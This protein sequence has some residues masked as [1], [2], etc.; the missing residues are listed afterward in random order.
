[1]SNVVPFGQQQV[2]A[3]A[4]VRSG[5]FGLKSPEQALALMALCEAEGLHPAKA[6]QRYHI[7]QGKAA[8]KA[9]TMLAEFQKA[10]G[11]VKWT[12]YT[13]KQVT[14]V[15]WHKAG[16]EVTISWDMI[17]AAKAGLSSKDVWRFYPRAMMRSRCISEGVRTVFPGVVEGIYTPEELESLPPD[18]GA[19]E[20]ESVRVADTSAATVRKVTKEPEMPQPSDELK[21]AAIELSKMGRA[22]FDDWFKSRTEDERKS[23]VRGL[24]GLH[25]NCELADERMAAAAAAEKAAADAANAPIE[26]EATVVD[27][28]V[29]DASEKEAMNSV[30]AD[31]GPGY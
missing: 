19:I 6:V 26:G 5:L 8:M 4:F 12:E 21:A 25:A 30:G 1:M 14:G 31:S 13:D 16:G 17:Q 9:D 24:K 29:A 22:V 23:L 11:T 3:E 20:G 15:F 7:V 2:L 18:E 27:S 10:G 28:D